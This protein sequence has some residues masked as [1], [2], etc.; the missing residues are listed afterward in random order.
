MKITKSF[1][2]LCPEDSPE[3][4]YYMMKFFRLKDTPDRGAP[5]SIDNVDICTAHYRQIALKV[6]EITETTP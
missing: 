3:P 5:K 6:G 2:D 1:C 4:A